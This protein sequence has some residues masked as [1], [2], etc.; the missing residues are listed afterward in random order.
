MGTCQW[1]H[2][3][4]NVMGLSPAPFLSLITNSLM[5]IIYGLLIRDAPIIAANMLGII[6]GSYC[7]WT[8]HIYKPIDIQNFALTVSMPIVSAACIAAFSVKRAI[9]M[10]GL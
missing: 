4:K 2:E 1:I 5:W 7:T 6:A 3:Q 10:V 8:Y 9:F